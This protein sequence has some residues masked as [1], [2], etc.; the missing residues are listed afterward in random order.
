VRATDDQLR[1]VWAQLRPTQPG[2]PASF[3]AT[4]ADP[5]RCRLVHIAA[6]RA[7]HGFP[8]AL[9]RA[10]RRRPAVIDPGVN[11]PALPDFPYRPASIDRKRAAAG[12]R[13][14]D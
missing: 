10:P 2:W 8:V 1:S 14:D 6:A 11:R 3:E 13:D 7:A 4:M 9:E 5:V 12:E